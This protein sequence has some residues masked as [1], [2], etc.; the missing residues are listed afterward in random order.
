M[1]LETSRA[2]PFV[3]ARATAHGRRADVMKYQ[4]GPALADAVRV[5]GLTARTLAQSAHVSPAVVSA[6]LHGREVQMATALRIARAVSQ[7]PVVPEL[8]QWHRGLAAY[9]GNAPCSAMVQPRPSAGHPTAR[10]PDAAGACEERGGSEA[11]RPA[12]PAGGLRV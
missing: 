1:V 5:G 7:A 11:P 6:A 12:L 2:R 10:R 8:Q 3:P 9:V 4:F